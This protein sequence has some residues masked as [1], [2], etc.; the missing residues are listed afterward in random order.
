MKKQVSKTLTPIAALAV[1]ATVTAVS[2][3]QGQPL[4]NSIRANIPFDFIVAD[5]KLP[6]G[7][8]WIHRV[9]QDSGT[10]TVV[11]GP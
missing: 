6:A 3:A 2:S 5:K 8:Y 11:S 7:D 10:V 9:S 4:A 1:I